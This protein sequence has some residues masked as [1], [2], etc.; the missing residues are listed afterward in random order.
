MIK[1]KKYKIDVKKI[2][3][4]FKDE[5]DF[6]YFKKKYGVS[7]KQVIGI[8]YHWTYKEI[9]KNLGKPGYIRRYGL[10]SQEIIDIRESNLDIAELSKK[11]NVTRQTIRNIKNKNTH[12]YL[13]IV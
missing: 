6:A 8:K 11:Y 5:G 7:R 10:T 1:D 4:I 12:I 2:Q 13:D 3:K 9:T